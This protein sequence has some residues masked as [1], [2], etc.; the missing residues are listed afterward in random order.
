MKIAAL[1]LAALI[2]G[3]LALVR[4]GSRRSGAWAVAAAFLLALAYGMSG[5]F[6]LLANLYGRI[7]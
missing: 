4:A 1:T 2:L 7:T 5:V 6:T 3:L